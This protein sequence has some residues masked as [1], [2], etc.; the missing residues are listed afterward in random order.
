MSQLNIFGNKVKHR[1]IPN[2]VFYTPPDLAKKLIEITDI[3]PDLHLY[4]PFMGEGVFYDNYPAE[5]TKKW[6][7]ITKG[8]DFFQDNEKIDFIISN[9]PFSM[10]TDILIHSSNIC[11]S[12]FGYIMPSY[13]LS[14]SRIMKIREY[15][16]S[17]SKIVY[18]EN[19]KEWK[20]GFQM[21]YVIFD[22]TSKNQEIITILPDNH[23]LTIQKKLF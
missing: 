3:T 7:E 17:I 1:E 16:F 19:P 11:R 14:Y 20:I 18:F 8:R 22:K 23:N 9:P 10:L 5:N 4:D 15:G 12:G 6:A 13:A 2:D 21:I